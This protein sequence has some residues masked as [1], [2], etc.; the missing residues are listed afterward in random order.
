MLRFH[1]DTIPT[2]PDFSIPYSV[3]FNE[4]LHRS[5]MNQSEVDKNTMPDGSGPLA[6]TLHAETIL[7][8]INGDQE[9]PLAGPDSPEDKGIIR[10]SCLRLL[11][12]V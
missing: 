9:S 11:A 6:D 12:D 3:A 2:I 5:L 4:S 10:C 7:Q 1:L 8:T